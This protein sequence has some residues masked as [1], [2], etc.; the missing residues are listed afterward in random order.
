MRQYRFLS[1][2]F[3]LFSLSSVTFGQQKSI[4]F[5]TYTIE[6]GLS[7]SQVTSIQQDAFGYIWIATQDGLNRYDGYNFSILKNEANNEN[8][9]P[10]NY[11]HILLPDK[12][13][14]L[15]LGTNR[16]IAKINP[17]NGL[18][19]K[20]NRQDYP[21]LKG[22]IFTHL[23]FDNQNKLWALS[24]KHGINVI[25]NRNKEVKIISE[26]KGS[27]SFTS[28]FIDSQKVVWIGTRYGQVFTAKPPYKNFT[29]IQNQELG[30]IGEINE[31]REKSPNEII[32]CT[33]TGPFLISNQKSIN[34][35]TES[36]KLRYTK[37]NCVYA[38]DS[39]HLWLGSAEKGLFL[40]QYDANGNEEIFNYYKNPYNNS[41]LADDNVVSIHEDRSGVIWVGT[42]KGVSKFDKYKQGFTTISL[43]NNPEEGLIDYNVWSF[44]EDSLENIYIGTKKDL[45]I[46]Q[47]DIQKFYHVYRP[48][49][50]QH[51]LLSI[52]VETP[53]RIWLGFDDGLYLL[54]INDLYFD[55][56][57]FTRIEF[58]DE[59]HSSNIRVYAIEPADNNRL[60]IGSRSGLSIINKN[61]LDFQFYEHT[62]AANS[63]GEGSVKIVYRDLKQKLWVVTTNSGL[64]NMVEREDSSFYFKH[65]PIKNYNENNGQI[66]SVLQT[67]E[68]FMWMG[69]YGEGLKRLDLKTKETVNYTEADGL[70]N[71]VI[72]GLIEDADG[73]LWTSTNKGLSKFNPKNE[74]FTTYSVK[75][76]LQS[77]EFNTNSYMKSSRGLLYFGGINGYNIFD[78]SEININPH[79]P[80]VIISSVVLSTKGTNKKELIAEHITTTKSLELEYSQNDISFEFV[81]TNY[82]NPSKTSYKYKLDGHEEEFTYLENENKV[83]YLNIPNGEYEL[84]VYAQS[85]DGVWSTNPTTIKLTITPPYWLTWWFR[86]CAILL[87]V[88]IG[89]AIYRRRIDKIRRQKVRLEIEVVKRTRQ[90]TEQSKKIQDQ[91][92]KVEIQ[93]A[94]IEHQNSLLA[95]EKEKVEQLLLNILPEGTAEEL[96][97]KGRS[98]ARYYRNVSVLFTDFVGFSKIAE[99]MKP[100]DLVQELD[101]YFSKFDEIIEKFDLEKIKTIG[102]SYMCA[103][104]VPIRNKSNAIEVC[105]AALE[106][107]SYITER[108]KV[109]PD[110]W[111]IR[112]GINTGEVIAGVIGIKRF[113]YDIWGASVNQAQRMEMHAHPGIVNVSGNT[114]EFIAPYFAC[115][116]R[117]KIQTKHKGMLDMYSVKGIKPEL[118]LDGNGIKPN[119][120]FWK[121]VDLHLYSSINYMKAERHIMKILETQLSPKLLYHSI[122]HTIDVTQAVERLAIME[123]ITDEDLFLLKS[124]ATYHDAGF[125]EK[126]E[127]NEEIGMRL[128]R[129]ILPKYGYGNEQIDVI[130]GLIKST[131]IPQS[132]TTHLQQIM[133]DADLDYLGRD[134]FHDI[135]DL[136]RRE[137]KEHGKLDSDRLWDEIQVKFLE[138]HTYFTDSA[139]RLRQE[140]KLIHIQDIKDKLE[141]FDYKD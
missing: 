130:D 25:N 104:G 96:K 85:A 64:Y 52:H 99:D 33:E 36:G 46:Y 2:F 75:D 66:T 34:T 72:Y 31:F 86:I 20:I 78:P 100:Q 80:T 122:N 136:L 92:K 112:I 91:K 59:D 14:N 106:I 32:A 135:A 44:A 127:N 4:K 79:P 16:G 53:E 77:N 125:I 110:T 71:N 114:H 26:I 47:R 121:I 11:V 109:D 9:L 21:Q 74:S 17:K 133:C 141:R 22:Y 39:N 23:A 107:N 28:L 68:G 40:V 102:D 12:D 56:Y 126:Y 58:L 98:K 129:E 89:F 30:S 140:K 119:K 87:L 103:G 95:K 49:N 105:L 117:G 13:K 118:S 57:K 93:H 6:E 41:S 10:N 65:Y 15:W 35:L 63:I 29:L 108:A 115:V 120:K 97:N 123:G 38:E 113:A 67:E 111:P 70:S 101:G 50:S 73:F 76:G 131:E 18:I 61:T 51:Y 88:L 82:S 45:S 138:Q 8:S 24:E 139:I 128:A 94:K 69:T 37:I 124:A 5:D 54:E 83:H 90:V 43:N 60:W 132:P 81:S 7:Q 116:Y 19:T 62:T 42:E 137:L 27:S 48:D 84:I 134:D 3:I 55:D 1:I